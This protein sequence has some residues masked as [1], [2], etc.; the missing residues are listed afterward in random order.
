VNLHSTRLTVLSARLHAIDPHA[1]LARGYAIAF[2]PDGH[3]VSDAA[4][5]HSNDDLRLLFAR[6]G[7]RV[8]VRSVLT[9]DRSDDER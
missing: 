6:G 3:A 1:V 7:A 4:R 8:Q 2:G 9:D 5:L